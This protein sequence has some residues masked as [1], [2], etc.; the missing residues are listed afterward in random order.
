MYKLSS[1]EIDM[2]LTKSAQDRYVYCVKR[3]A[4][5]G[6]AWVL[7]DDEGFVT[8]SDSNGNI[9]L[10]IWPFK[11]YA[12]KLKFDEWEACEPKKLTINNLLKDVLPNLSDDN[13]NIAVFMIP[14]S[15]DVV[16]VSADK[17]SKD[18]IYER[19]KFG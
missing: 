6:A 10:P 3:V 11:D 5:W 9:S 4:D 15:L 8:T 14:E 13:I 16:T 19:S 12:L 17:L 18:L 7:K 1:K 2:M